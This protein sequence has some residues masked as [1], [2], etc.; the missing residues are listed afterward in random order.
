MLAEHGVIERQPLLEGRSMYIV[1]AP[2]EK[3]PEK[4][5]ENGD[6]E[7]VRGSRRHHR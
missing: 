6:A 7:R 2:L 4:K 3:R 5:S 1:M